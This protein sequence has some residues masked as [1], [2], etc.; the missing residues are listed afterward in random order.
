MVERR[1]WQKREVS[2][3]ISAMEIQE[4]GDSGGGDAGW[5]HKRC[6]TTKM[7]YWGKL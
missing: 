4:G 3:L 6:G 2:F 1:G 7:A 5:Q